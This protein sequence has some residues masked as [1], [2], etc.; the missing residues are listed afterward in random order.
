[1]TA[2]GYVTYTVPECIEAG[3]YLVRHEIIAL[4]SAGTEGGGKFSLK[5][6]NKL[7]KTT[8]LTFIKQ[9]NFT[10]AATRS[11]SPAVAPPLP[12]TWSRSPVPTQP[13]TPASCTT[14]TPLRPTPS[15]APLCSPAPAPAPLPRLAARPPVLLPPP[16]VLLRRPPPSPP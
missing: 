14:P 10:L 16:A 13:T 11:T 8:M 1:M 4:H 2:G 12:P 6:N 5:H 3:A 9:L 7:T 15:P